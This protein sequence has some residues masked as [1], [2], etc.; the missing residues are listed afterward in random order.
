MSLPKPEV[1]SLQPVQ[2][3]ARARAAVLPGLRGLPA[4]RAL[5]GRTLGTMLAEQQ[6]E[7]QGEQQE[8]RKKNHRRMH[9]QLCCL[10]Q[11]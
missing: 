2:L 5:L 9:V 4:M 11:L 3:A 7:Q 10:L 1:L 8:G 6:G